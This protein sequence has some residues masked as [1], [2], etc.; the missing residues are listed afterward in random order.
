MKT[1]RHLS[2]VAA[3]LAAA[4]LPAVLQA[5]ISVLSNTVEERVSAPGDHY[6]GTIVIANPTAT[7]Q[8]ARIYQTD[9]TFASDGTSS[10][11][12]AGTTPRSNASWVLPQSTRVVVPANSQLAVQYTVTVPAGDSL[13]G[14]YWSMVMVEGTANDPGASKPGAKPSMQLGAV[15]RYAI[16]VAT[17][18]GFTG[19]RKVKFAEPDV[20]NVDG[21]ATLDLDV[22]DTGERGYRP[23]LW[24]EVYDATGGLRA[25]AKQSRGLLYPGTSLRQHF[26]LGALP[27]GTYKAVVF[28]DTGEDSVFA[29]QYTI[30][31]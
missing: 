9:Y 22:Q 8:T 1:I 16:Q 19:T 29:T 31:F 14:T 11:E 25:K 18:I 23:T 21:K 5:Q 12:P 13:H 28:A 15:V 24:I 26:D 3:F 10:F 2:H 17:H 4:C 7:P 30:T 27:A 6:S 20:R